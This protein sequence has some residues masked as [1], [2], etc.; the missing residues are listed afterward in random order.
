GTDS[1][2]TL[3]TQPS[4]PAGGRSLDLYWRVEGARSGHGP[5]RNAHVQVAGP[6]GQDAEHAVGHREPA[7]NLTRVAEPQ[8]EPGP[9]P[10]G[11]AVGRPHGDDA[12]REVDA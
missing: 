6:R 10:Q 12:T 5:V 2:S 9:E 11:Q 1:L 7:N 3:S 8:L 4:S